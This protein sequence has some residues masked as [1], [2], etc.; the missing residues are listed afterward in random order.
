M[1]SG[2][3][4]GVGGVGNPRVS[5]FSKRLVGAHLAST[6][7]VHA[8]SLVLDGDVV[9]QELGRLRRFVVL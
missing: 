7:A 1:F 5:G 9:Q 3:K 6:G 8:R 4:V 2:Q